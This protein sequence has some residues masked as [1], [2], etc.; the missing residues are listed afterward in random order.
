MFLLLFAGCVSP[1]PAPPK[2]RET[3]IKIL[4]GVYREGFEKGYEQ[5]V[6]DCNCA[7]S[8]ADNAL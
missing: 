5:A 3:A 6:M 8:L 4:F 7:S 2:T 1:A